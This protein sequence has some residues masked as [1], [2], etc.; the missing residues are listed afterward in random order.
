MRELS[1][2][3]LLRYLKNKLDT[4]EKLQKISVSG[5]ISNY[6]RHFSGHLYFTL[7]DEYAAIS[8][9]MFKS[10]AVSL[11]FEPKNGDKVLVYANTSIFESSGQ[12]QLYVLKMEQKG[13][14]DLF[15]RY[16]ELKKRFPN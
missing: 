1:V 3:T 12:L 2:S 15:A 5:E 16:E 4:D 10:A 6:H 14:G 8:C 7:K 9:V 11:R 13:A